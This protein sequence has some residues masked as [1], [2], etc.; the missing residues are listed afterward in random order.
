MNTLERLL[1][2]DP[3]KLE[4]RETK[5]IKSK[6]LAFLFGENEPVDVTIQALDIRELEFIEEFVTDKNGNANTKRYIDANFKICAK[7]IIDPP[8]N[9][10]ELMAHYGVKSSERVVEKIFQAEATNIAT[11]IMALSGADKDMT[12]EIKN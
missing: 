2:T 3:E 9:S 4:E 1:K 10:E 11:D 8:V 5:V 12:S 7:G 6:R